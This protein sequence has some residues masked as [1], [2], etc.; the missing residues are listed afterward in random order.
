MD[1]VAPSPPGPGTLFLVGTP[2]GNLQDMTERA[3]A[4]L[5]RVG[6]VAAEDTRRTGRLLAAFGVRARLMSLFE[7]NEAARIPEMLGILGEG[8]DVALVSD[9]GMPALS[10]PGYRLVAACIERGIEVDVVPGPSAAVT[11][12]VISGL[13]TDR[14]VFEGFLPR[15]G[16]KRV[17]RLRDLAV[18]TRTIVLFESPRRLASTLRDLEAACG[19][20]RVAVARELTKLHQEVLRG[21]LSEVLAGLGGEDPRGEIVVVLEGG[22]RGPGEGDDPETAFAIARALASGGARKREAARRASDLTGA[23]TREIYERLAREAG[24]TGSGDGGGIQPG[25]GGAAGS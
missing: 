2:I 17:E 6:L 22:R 11:A 24:V 4:T 12:L 8:T 15:S 25:D 13:P 20:R 14:F 16:R 21:H 1:T 7:G 5:A 18:E 10:D 9:A 3:R 23:S 19:D